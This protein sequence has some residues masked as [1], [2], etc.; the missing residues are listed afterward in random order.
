MGPWQNIFSPLQFSPAGTFF[1]PEIKHF[2]TVHRVQEKKTERK[3]KRKKER[4]R[5]V[6]VEGYFSLVKLNNVRKI[7]STKKEWRLD[8]EDKNTIRVSRLDIFARYGDVMLR[9]RSLPRKSVRDENVANCKSRYRTSSRAWWI[10]LVTDRL[11]FGSN[12]LTSQELDHA[13]AITWSV[14][15]TDLRYLLNTSNFHISRTALRVLS[16][17]P[18]L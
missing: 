8:K 14:S 17:I 12:L 7:Q 16:D 9:K 6:S 5:I 15:N 11:S 13:S 18:K 4:D 2:W 3:R 10:R 1:A